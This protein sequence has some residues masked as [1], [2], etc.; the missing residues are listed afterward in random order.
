MFNL[1]LKINNKKEK[2]EGGTRKKQFFGTLIRYDTL[3]IIRKLILI[4]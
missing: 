2:K 1:D 4:Y 3:P